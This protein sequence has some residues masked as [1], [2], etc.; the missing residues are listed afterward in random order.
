[1]KV[2]VTLFN[3]GPFLMVFLFYL[4][5]IF[6]VNPLPVARFERAAPYVVCCLATL[7]LKPRIFKF[8]ILICFTSRQPVSGR[9]MLFVNVK[10]TVAAL[11]R[12]ETKM[13][14]REQLAGTQIQ[15]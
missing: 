8:V 13:Q 3:D 7:L 10:L 4:E 9:L 1:M 5:E 2:K 11:I 12:F 14:C 15:P 6:I